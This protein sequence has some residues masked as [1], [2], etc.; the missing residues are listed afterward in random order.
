MANLV[1]T[2]SVISIASFVI[3]AIIPLLQNSFY[4]PVT[5][6]KWSQLE[7]SDFKGTPQP[8]TQYG[9]VI[10]SKVYLEYDSIDH[11][12]RAYAG[13]NNRRSWVKTSMMNSTS[14]LRHEQYH[15]NI[16]EYHS[17][18]LNEELSQSDTLTFNQARVMLNRTNY[19]LSVMQDE[20]DDETDHS[21]IR[22]QQ[23]FWE[24][25]VDSL[26]QVH[27]AADGI[28]TDLI[29]GLQVWFPGTPEF[30]SA[31]NDSEMPYR[32]F[33]LDKYDMKFY[34]T[35][36]QFDFQNLS[37]Y[38]SNLTDFYLKDSMQIDSMHVEMGNGYVMAYTIASDTLNNQRLEQKWFGTPTRDYKISASHPI[39][40]EFGLYHQISKTFLNS[41]KIVNTDT[42]WFEANLNYTSI[43][44]S[45]TVSSQNI[46]PKEGEGISFCYTN[47][48]DW[49]IFHREPFIDPDGDLYLV[50]DILRH[51]DSLVRQ[52]FVMINREDLLDYPVDSV[53][54]VIIIPSE[55]LKDHNEIFFGYF[56][57]EDSAKDCYTF[58]KEPIQY[59]K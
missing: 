41:F 47:D 58:Y 24:Y 20:Y 13:Q 12:Y 39:S 17:R 30:T 49:S 18:L 3:I 2:K 38:E 42:I 9:A 8:F 57:K 22:E 10:S 4:L 32:S 35:T 21:L 59:S 7:W 50:Y 15:F 46:P 14:G 44:R 48:S 52:N 25:K 53:N 5:I 29:S 37:D 51:A 34:A 33:S 45:K 23:N 26:L 40:E 11:R 27:S 19:K 55:M 43:P 56:T 54:Q 31:L 36:F 28:S 1:K 16:T 6:K